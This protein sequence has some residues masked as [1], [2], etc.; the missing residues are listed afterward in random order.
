[1]SQP[2]PSVKINRRAFLKGV[3]QTSLLTHPLMS[4]V[5]LGQGQVPMNLLI[6]PL[7]H[8]W[9][10]GG[11]DLGT[12]RD[13]TLPDWLSPFQAIKDQT[14]IIDGLL[15]TY[16][17]NAH[18]VSYGDLL[19]GGIQP[20]HN[21]QQGATIGGYFPKPDGPSIDTIMANAWQ[22]QALRMS[23]GFDFPISFDADGRWLRAFQSP[24]EVF[25]IL[26][27]Q[28]ANVTRPRPQ[29]SRISLQ[30]DN[31]LILDYV[32]QQ[33]S[34]IRGQLPRASQHI[35]EVH[36]ASLNQTAQN[37]GINLQNIQQA[38]ACEAPGRP[39]GAHN[40]SGQIDGFLDLT[41][42]AFSC[43]THRV[44]VLG[45]GDW[46][47]RW[48]WTDIN[49]QE[50]QGNIFDEDYHQAI[51][52]SYGH[53]SSEYP[54]R[55]RAYEGAVRWFAAKIARFAQG[56]QGIPTSHGNLLDQTVIVLTG[57]VGEGNHDTRQ[58]PYIVIGGQAALDTG[59]YIKVPTQTLETLDTPY[60]SF[61]FYD[62]V[63][64]STRTEPDFWVGL[65]R[66]MGVPLRQLGIPFKNNDP[67]RL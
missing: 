12:E 34:S 23:A 31:K 51:A 13:F 32:N 54:R 20:G 55:R 28:V 38:A 26:A 25:N 2:K 59:R 66:A 41:T 42:T 44:A 56:L 49:G 1:M 45:M 33:L 19:T 11:L 4:Q 21:T 67:L 30:D 15:G 60:G 24:D 29:N 65:A 7:A 17:D 53:G 58:K 63:A 35:L 64:V 40:L 9:G 6:V 10:G 57:E 62:R 16:W 27:R 36:Q 61:P 5:A 50:R 3:G 48:S 43:G 39:R 47:E 22:T 8:G 18:D 37:L 52:H 46:L 14:T